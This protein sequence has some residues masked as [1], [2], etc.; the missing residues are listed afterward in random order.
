MM[1]GLLGAG[2]LGFASRKKK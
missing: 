2:V 1:L